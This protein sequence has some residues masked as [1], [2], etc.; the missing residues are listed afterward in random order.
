MDVDG[1]SEGWAPL[2]GLWN[3]VAQILGSDEQTAGAGFLVAEDLL[4]TCAHVVEAAGAGPG[5]QVSLRFPHVDGARRVEGL[6]LEGNWR[7]PGGEDVAVIRL[8]DTPAGVQPLPL[9]SAGGGRGHRVRSFGFPAQAPPGG[10]FG[11]GT[12]G[13][14]LP[15]TECGKGH[16]QLTA[17][18]DLTT[19]FSGGPV[20]DEVTGL[21]VGMLTE[22]TAPD[23]YE[24]GQGIAYVT[25]T[26]TL[27]E[28]CPTLALQDVC[29][30]RGLE[31]FTAEHAQWYEGRTDAVRQV[32][33]NLQQHRVTL[34]L[35]PSG[36]GKSSLVQAGVLPKLAAGT[37]PGS[38]R[39]LPVVTRPGQDLLAE[40]E[41]AG[42]PGAAED[43]IAEAVTRRLASE[44]TAER[45]VLIIDQF[46]ELL[47]L[48]STKGHMERRLAATEQITA[49]VKSHTRLS[50]ILI[51]RDDFY[52]QQAA[53]APKLLEA[54][55]PGLLNIPRSLSE[56]DLCD[57]ITRPAQAAGGRLEHGLP[58]QVIADVLVTT[59]EA[60][61]ARQAPVTVLPLLELALS[62]LWQ[63]RDEGCL[64]H[65][66]YRRI[67]GVTGSLTTW[68]D[69]ALD[70][71]P[72]EQRP[73]AQRLL[74]SLVRPADPD[75][76]IPAIREQVPLRELRELAANSHSAS[77]GAETVN[78]VL[79]ALVRHRIITTYTP[80]I[81]DPSQ[82][83]SAE[84]VAELIHDA[85]IHDWPAL[86]DWVAQ[87]HRFR[88][89]FERTRHQ[90]ARWA[91]SGDP[92]DLLRG[93]AL[94]EGLEWAQRRHLPDDMAAFLT[95]GK[96][97]QQA[98][99]RRS[100]RLNAILASLLALVLVAAGGAIWQRQTAIAERQ[101]AL[102]RQ[103]AME[104]DE[105]IDT[106]PDNAALMAVAAYR[107][108]ATREAIGSLTK[109]A[110]LPLR[111]S[112]LGHTGYVNDVAFSPD[113]HTLATG[114]ADHTVRLWDTAT[115]T[116]HATLKG[117]TN[118]VYAV[119]FSRD[120][121]TLAG[122][123]AD[124]TVR[125]WD[126]TTGTVRSVLHGHTDA[127][128]SVA[129][130]PDG[131]TLATGSDDHTVRLWDTT[132]GTTRTTLHGH[133]DVVESV[134]FSPD[135]R[136]LATGSDDHTVRLWDT[137]TGTVRS[138]L[139][140]RTGAVESVAFSPDGRTLA[141][142]SDDYSVMLWDTATGR[143]SATLTGFDDAV[144]SV[145]FSPDGRT[146]AAGSAD[147]TVRLWNAATREVRSVF[148]GHTD[149]VESVTFSPD[150]R[151]LASASDD[152]TIRLWNIAPAESG[153]TLSGHTG[154]VYSVAFS[155]D[156]RTLA[157]AS[158]DHTI[159]LWDTATRRTRATLRGHTSD[160]DAVAFSPD[161]RTLA[162]GSADRTVRL[163]DTA[164]GRIR[165]TLTGHTDAVNAVTFSPD[166]RTLASVSGDATVRLWNVAA[167]S[168][169]G[170]P[171][172]SADNTL[173]AVAFSP[174]GRT[175]AV[176]CL[177]DTALLLDTATGK[178]R[179]TLHGHT[180]PV[181]S[182]AF[183]PD[184]RAF[185]SG[186]ADQTVQL[187]DVATDTVRSTL[188]G[189]TGTV[190]SV[191]FSP[192]GRALA[193]GSAD[194]TVR[195]WDTG[196]GTVRSVLNGH[197]D[198]VGAVAF[199]PDG[200]TLASGS[201]DH[202]IRLWDATMP[203]PDL[204]IQHICQAVNRDLTPQER[205][206]FHT[207]HSAEHV[208]PATHY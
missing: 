18:N 68:C 51:M 141:T 166:G 48:P 36:S 9:G 34:L 155:P 23:T 17:A 11:Y 126:A 35:G 196:T 135:G 208:C 92:T 97:Q 37:L 147:N 19:G 195:L 83:R 203:T 3:A 154:R 111:R 47:T 177:D 79:T 105:L 7:S 152:H 22:I 69:T 148:K 158:D 90:R 143:S 61:S 125:L 56:P 205:S 176:G 127:V 74:T 129:F 172:F 182:V 30:Y 187:W 206:Q 98:T 137:T 60:A 54:A 73:V 191:A 28:I 189:H 123:G 65:D 39:W 175:L 44:P 202:T 109:A 120:G 133:T 144:Y 112:L 108:S 64:T 75:H 190:Y 52:P 78:E 67:G 1:K 207:N 174:D 184:G 188:S 121:R 185:A 117:S 53:L 96:L 66:A 31:P 41:R 102:S 171:F 169:T 170:R 80:Q 5:Q 4:V 32:L 130:S 87:D 29:P 38:D 132:T 8:S 94:A 58:E 106:R 76:R 70:Q 110:E 204:L 107:T 33:T 194:H 181:R 161:G 128:E 138:V 21:V 162:S 26:Q 151:T 42:L 122:S 118:Y 10:H 197:T 50:V 14:L 167:K 192:N 201:D 49:A 193:S 173:A 134:A 198:E 124:A 100:R 45:I 82:T 140:G 153:A 15:T 115:G 6:V 72:A 186:S 150:G 178:T 77:A 199:S 149:T 142:G 91:Q 168:S 165:A 25:P 164:T 136:T 86:R 89:W 27:R 46:E 180:D 104:S 99:I 84:P 12:V 20:A 200:R 88:A 179:A 114:S 43:G 183:S 159:R 55:V 113:G 93:T 156:G 145:A 160:V 119:A 71:L 13:D 146:V 62:Q 57:I 101:Q 2:S 163:W 103:L 24:R 139:H 95:A 131:R 59:P 116:T 85:L 40:L 81:S 157:S 63:R 16:L